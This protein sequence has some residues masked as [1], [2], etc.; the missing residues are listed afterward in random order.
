MS[1]EVVVRDAGGGQLE[2]LAEA[3]LARRERGFGPLAR[4]E[5]ADLRADQPRRAH[6]PLVGLAH[7]AARDGKHADGPRVEAHREQERAVH[8]GLAYA[9]VREGARVAAHVR[10]EH[11][12]TALPDLANQPLPGRDGVAA[13]VLGE[14]GEPPD[15]APPAFVAAHDAGRLAVLEAEG[16]G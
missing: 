14:P 13:R 8:A 11:R 10:A 3:R 16:P 6:E 4:Q 15:A 5:L 2:G 9:R 1:G 12:R 7:D